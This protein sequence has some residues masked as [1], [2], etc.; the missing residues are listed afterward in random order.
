MVVAFIAFS[1]IVGIIAGFMP[2]LF[3]SKVNAINA[4]RNVSSV[5]VF[6]HVP[7]RRALVVI[8]YTVTLIFITATAVGYVQYKNILAFDLGFNT[9]NIL[10]INMQGNNPKP[11]RGTERNARSYRPVPVD[12]RHQCWECLGR[13]YEIQ[14][15]K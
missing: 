11:S 5:K 3:F 13:L 4:L 1:V 8:Q 14:R 10:N 12:D 15:F 7:L 2:A 6:K 9:E